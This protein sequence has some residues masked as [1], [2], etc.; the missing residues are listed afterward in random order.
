MINREKHPLAEALRDHAA[1]GKFDAPL[2]YQKAEGLELI[3]SSLGL[4]G[5]EGRNA[6][7]EAAG[8][9]Y[10]I[11]GFVWDSAWT[12]DPHAPKVAAEPRATK[13]AKGG[14]RKPVKR[15][16]VKPPVIVQPITGKPFDTPDDPELGI[17]P[18]RPAGL[19]AGN[20]GR[21]M[22]SAQK[23]LCEVDK[24]GDSVSVRAPE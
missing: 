1:T 11:T 22:N 10:R 18:D 8:L 2:L 21:R 14:K 6:Y 19:S 12:K 16:K 4:P 23:L 15:R 9:Y 20:S 7:Q 17:V 5:L 3:A 13:T 24:T